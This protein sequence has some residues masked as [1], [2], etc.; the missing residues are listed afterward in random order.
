MLPLFSKN[1]KAGIKKPIKNECISD[2]E[3]DGV[4]FSQEVSKKL[5]ESNQDLHCHYS[6]LPS[7]LAY[8]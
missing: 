7:V 4:R 1:K 6:G 3:I 2:M 8:Q 5:K